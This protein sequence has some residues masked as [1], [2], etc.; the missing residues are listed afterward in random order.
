MTSESPIFVPSRSPS[1]APVTPGDVLFKWYD[2]QDR[3]IDRTL[4]GENI[5]DNCWM[6]EG[7]LNSQVRAQA[8]AS[9]VRGNVLDMLL[10]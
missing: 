2:V 3:L 4:M 5:R 9:S 10:D 1:P 8:D 7:I 6:F